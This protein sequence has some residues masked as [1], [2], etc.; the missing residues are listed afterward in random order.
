MRCRVTLSAPVLLQLLPG[1][2]SVAKEIRLTGRLNDQS[3][4]VW[5][6]HFAAFIQS[7]TRR[8]AESVGFSTTG[9]VQC[10]KLSW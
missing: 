4:A 6:V 10:V 3:A 9:A 7:E 1:I 2:D 8:A 5:G